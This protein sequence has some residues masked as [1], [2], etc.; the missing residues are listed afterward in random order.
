MRLGVLLLACLSMAAPFCLQQPKPATAP[1][2]SAALSEAQALYRKG[3]FD[4][5]IVR[6]N[7][8]LKADP[9]SGAA[10]AGIIRCYLKQDKVQEADDTLQKALQSVPSHPD[11]RVAEG[12]LLFRQG[13]IP[14]AEKLFNEVIAA[15]P[16]PAQPNA[17]PNARAYLGAAR[18]ASANAM[19][20]REHI[21]ISRA[22]ALDKSDPEIRRLWAEMQ[23]P[24]DRVQAL[25][26]YLAQ[27]ANDDEDTRRRL[28]EHLDLLRA[29]QS[30]QRD[31]CRPSSEV[32]STKLALRPILFGNGGASGS[33]LN[34]LVN[35]KTVRLLLDT[36]TSGILISGKV[37][38]EAGLKSVSEIRMSGI[39]DKPDAPSHVAWADSVQIGEMPFHNCP[40]YVVERV[41]RDSDGIIGA[42]V[43]SN[44]LIELDFPNSLFS[45]TPLPPR[46]GET[47]SEASLHVGTEQP[48]AG[49]EGKSPPETGPGEESKTASLFEDRYLA[50]E[51]HSYVQIFRV[52][53]LL[54]VPTTIDEKS[55]KLFLL[56]TGAFDNTITPAAAREV[57][58]V[59]RA[60]RVDV[61]GLNGD[62]K[63]VYVA[64]QV[65]LD[66]GHLR[67]TVPNIVSIDM[68]R[69]SRAAGTEVSGAL[70]MAMLSLLKVRIDYRDALADF[71]YTPR[72]GRR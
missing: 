70:G 21:L 67:Q 56:D 24:S 10:Y 51:M 72:P 50:P 9:A 59:H 17:K 12:E 13:E 37:A 28:Q 66:F 38:A 14:E 23:P 33:G 27:T 62:V 26:D 3:S 69:T 58:K 29:S 52:G 15:P 25:A 35:G 36:G 55:S 39:G 43:F 53:H 46:P 44:F 63:K 61:R 47:P 7:E 31:H 68:T 2:R 20:A 5:G 60:P 65:T 6:Y 8:V 1:D 48:G 34:V 40:V 11:V 32:K 45:L 42:D 41:P 64:D 18:V 57:T 49:T 54:L 71:Q 19:Y 4:L 16:D 30:V 22:Y